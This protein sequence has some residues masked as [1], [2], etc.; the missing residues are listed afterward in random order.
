MEV[1]F[2]KFNGGS[3]MEQNQIPAEQVLQAQFA[4]VGQLTF[5]IE[6]L[7]QQLQTFEQEYNKAIER[8]QE[9]ETKVKTLEDIRDKGLNKSLLESIK[10]EE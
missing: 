1:D 4:K 7:N 10:I 6:I 8:N 5:Q 2:F 9:L 3:K